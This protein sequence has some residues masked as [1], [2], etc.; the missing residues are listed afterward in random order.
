[1]N[2]MVLAM[3]W[4]SAPEAGWGDPVV[5]TRPFRTVAPQKLR[6]SVPLVILLHGWGSS[7]A[8]QDEHFKLSTLVEKRGFV[9][10]LPD[11]EVGAKGLR[12]WNATDVC[13]GFGAGGD[14]VAYVVAMIRDL[15]ARYP[16]DPK[17]VFIVGFS[18]GGFMAHRLA[19]EH[20]GLVA[21][22]VSVA[23]APWKDEAKC[24]PSAPVSVLQVHGTD[25]Q[26]IRY[27]GG[28]MRGAV[29][30]GAEAALTMWGAKNGCSGTTLEPAGADLDLVSDLPDEE[31][32]RAALAGC[33]RNTAVELWRVRKGEHI[34]QFNEAFAAAIYDWL[35][36]HPR[37]WR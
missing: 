33:P 25:D 9:L 4:A 17:R 34:P 12:F 28:A 20:S 3:L 23:G 35:M 29:H 24:A 31:T 8:E 19:C 10:A 11:G 5:W 6:G 16:I 32:Q 18:N 30:P 2:W 22:V 26:T 7:G 15:K 1:M 36:A 27:A 14:D 21:A 37:P 13:C